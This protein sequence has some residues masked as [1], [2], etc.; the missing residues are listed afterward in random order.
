MFAISSAVDLSGRTFFSAYRALLGI[1]LVGG[2][3][4]VC[5][6]ASCLSETLYVTVVIPT[7]SPDMEFEVIIIIII[8][9]TNPWF[10][11]GGAL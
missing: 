8:I 6:F 4:T 9:T 7:F 1:V 11:V 2:L 10:V 5:P 3:L